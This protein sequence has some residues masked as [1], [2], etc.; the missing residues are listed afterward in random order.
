MTGLPKTPI[1]N[2]TI[3]SITAVLNPKQSPYYYY[4]HDTK[5]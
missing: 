3:S 2:P 5:T 4:L 1:N